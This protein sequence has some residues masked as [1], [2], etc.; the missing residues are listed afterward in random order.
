M[1][2]GRDQREA[3][4]VDRCLCFM[5]HWTPSPSSFVGHAVA[6]ASHLCVV[7]GVRLPSPLVEREKWFGE[8]RKLCQRKH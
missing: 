6:V 1:R 5:G 3:L 7:R 2:S 8:K 4:I